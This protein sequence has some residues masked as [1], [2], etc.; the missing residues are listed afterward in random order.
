M[1]LVLALLL[2]SLAGASRRSDWRLVAEPHPRERVSFYVT[3]PHRN[4]ASF[5]QHVDD[6]TSPKS[7]RYGQWMSKEE[8]LIPHSP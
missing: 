1:S 8:G 6:I 3:L 2:I 4:L 7:M 5:T